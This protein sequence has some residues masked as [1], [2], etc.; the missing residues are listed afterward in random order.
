MRTPDCWYAHHDPETNAYIVVLEDVA[1]AEQGD[2]MRGCS[3]ADIEAAIDELVLLH[4]AT[5]G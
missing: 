1:P 3:P 2:Q 5:L 4:G